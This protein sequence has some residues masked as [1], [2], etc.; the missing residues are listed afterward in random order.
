M[1][2]FIIF[3][4]TLVVTVPIG[5]ADLALSAIADTLLY[6]IDKMF[7]TTDKPESVPVR[8]IG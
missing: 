8:C 1:A 7:E 5:L 2:L 4:P 3:P 6:P